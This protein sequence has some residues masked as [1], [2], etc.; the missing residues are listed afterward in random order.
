MK[1]FI[2]WPSRRGRM[3]VMLVLTAALVLNGGLQA[4]AAGP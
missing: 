2:G 3:I 1:A 4:R